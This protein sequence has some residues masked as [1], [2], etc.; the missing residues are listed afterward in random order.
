MRTRVVVPVAAVLV[1][2][3]VAVVAILTATG[4]DR[5]SDFGEAPPENGASLPG[6]IGLDVDE[7]EVVGDLPPRDTVIDDATWSQ[8]AGWIARENA[9]GRPVVVNLWASWCEPCEREI[10]LLNQAA[11]DHPDIA[12]LGVAANDAAEDARAAVDEFGIAFPSVRDAEYDQ[13]AF[14]VGARVLPTT[15]VFDAEGTMV[16]RVIGEL[17]RRSLQDL[18]GSVQ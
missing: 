17:S 8:V 11:G 7:V 12:F 13:V 14:T 1:V 4:D 16:G 15:V 9:E 6:D 18:L 5:V 3:A 2:V 10:P